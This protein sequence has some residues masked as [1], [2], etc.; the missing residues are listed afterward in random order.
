MCDFQ[1]LKTQNVEFS[2]IRN[3]SI[4][5]AKCCGK[6]IANQVKSQSEPWF[7]QG[8]PWDSVFLYHRCL[9]LHTSIEYCG[10]S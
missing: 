6:K 1:S 3:D 4:E 2:M 9:I 10:S 7:K 8:Y 5:N